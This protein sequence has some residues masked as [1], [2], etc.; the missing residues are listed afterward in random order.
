MSSYLQLL[1]LAENMRTDTKDL[2]CLLDWNRCDIRQSLLHLQFWAC[3]GGGQQVHRPLPS[4]GKDMTLKK[5]TKNSWL[6]I[7]ICEYAHQKQLV[8]ICRAQ[9]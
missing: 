4:S 7:V 8:S 1:C 3:S 5:Y 2:S 9:E 6:C